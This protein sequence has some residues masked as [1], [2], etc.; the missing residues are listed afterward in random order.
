MNRAEYSESVRRF[1]LLS[2]IG[3]IQFMLLSVIAMMFYTGGSSVDHQSAGYSI[4]YNLLSDLG[5]TIAYSG[6]SNVVSSLIYN[7]S[8]LSMGCFLVPFFIAMPKFLGLDTDAKWF[9]VPGSLIGILMAITFI[10]A[11]L[12]PADILMD[13]HFL[14]GQIAFITGLPLAISYAMAVFASENFPRLYA[15]LFALFG[16]I[17]FIF[18][19]VM[20]IY[21]GE[22][23]G[24]ISMI[25]A[26]GQKIAVYGLIGCIMVQSYGAFNQQ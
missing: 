16:I 20:F 8:L 24:E 17:Q 3:C 15:Y 19:M 11:A 13:I 14:L 9:S 21:L 23:G 4:L 10:G 22:G 6:E 7:I 18:L 5:R 26:I 25:F 2:M 1:F 12:T